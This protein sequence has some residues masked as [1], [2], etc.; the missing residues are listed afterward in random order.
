MTEPSPGVEV[1]KGT[2]W[3][4]LGAHSSRTRVCWRGLW[5]AG[6]EELG[7]RQRRLRTGPKDEADMWQRMDWRQ[8]RCGEARYG[9]CDPDNLWVQLGTP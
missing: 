1:G 8:Q 6:R 4:G 3:R 5:G 2:N 7:S 9:R